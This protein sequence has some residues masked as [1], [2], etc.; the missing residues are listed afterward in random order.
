MARN[1]MYGIQNGKM[2]VGEKIDNCIDNVA[3]ANLKEC[4]VVKNN[5]VSFSVNGSRIIG[6]FSICYGKVRIVG[7]DNSFYKVNQVKN[8]QLCK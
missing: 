5:R 4:G 7:L 6:N 1:F 8:L 2:V 3:I